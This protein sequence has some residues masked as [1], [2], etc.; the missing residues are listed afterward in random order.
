MNSDVHYGS[1][2]GEQNAYIFVTN[3]FASCL[4]RTA[5]Q[6]YRRGLEF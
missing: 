5:D 4:P 6:T 2:Q 3:T 1:I